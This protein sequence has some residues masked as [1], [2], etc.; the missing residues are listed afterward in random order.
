MLIRFWYIPSLVFIVIFL[1]FAA[2]ITQFYEFQIR[3][4]F[5]WWDNV[6]HALVGVTFGL[7][8]LWFIQVMGWNLS[9]RL[10][11]ISTISVV[12]AL[13]ILWEVAELALL[14]IAPDIAHSLQ[15][16]S[17]SISEATVDSLSNLLGVV[18]LVWFIGRK[19]HKYAF[20]DRDGTIIW[21]PEKPEGVDPRETFPLQSADQVQFMDGAIEGLKALQDEGYKLV[22]VT[23][24]SF[25]GTPK[26]PQK[27]FD[28]VMERMHSDLAKHGIKFEFE[29]ICPH[30][31]DDGCE[32]R[33]PK[34]G[35][36]KEFLAARPA[37]LANSLMFGDRA[38]DGEF[39]KKLGVR[40]VKIDTNKQFKF[41]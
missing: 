10:M 23:N 11:T 33:K 6:L 32:C 36:L 18:G 5:V 35:G 34:T 16:Y 1:H 24:Q 8:W 25:L 21:E 40:F 4:G 20:I 12:V 19:K 3:S 30:G 37:D 17:T 22:L 26:H 9:P 7:A 13:A 29:M 27:V 2:V 41:S 15:M 31:P 28:Q 38:T 14:L 39:A